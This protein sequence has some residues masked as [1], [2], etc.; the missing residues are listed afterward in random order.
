MINTTL[1]I[2]DFYMITLLDISV[3]FSNLS[4]VFQIIKFI[5]INISKVF[6]LS[7]NLKS[8]LLFLTTFPL[9]ESWKN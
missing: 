3:L 2:H 8:T 1:T 9:N 4:Y 7:L 5:L 6:S